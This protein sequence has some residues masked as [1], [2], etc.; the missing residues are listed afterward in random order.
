MNKIN[1]IYT[2]F[3][4]MRLGNIRTIIWKRE[5]ATVDKGAA[6]QPRDLY[7][8]LHWQESY[9]FPNETVQNTRQGVRSLRFPCAAASFV[10]MPSLGRQREMCLVVS[11]SFSQCLHSAEE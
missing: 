8:Y 1:E 2:V 3:L 10:S 6:L 5:S 4:D 7:L 11:S 9:C